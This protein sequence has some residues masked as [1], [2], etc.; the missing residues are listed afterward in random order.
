MAGTKISDYATGNDHWT[1]LLST[2]E[3][4]RKGKMALSLTNY[5][6]SSLPA[7][8][9]GSYLE[10]NGAL[11]GFTSEEA[12]GG[13]ATTDNINYVMVDPTPVTAAWT[14]VTPTWAPNK[15]AWMDAGEAKRYI[16]GCCFITP[17][18][19]HKFLYNKGRDNHFSVV[20]DIGDWNMDTGPAN[21]VA[22]GLVVEKIQAT[23]VM[24]RDDTDIRHYTLLPDY[25]GVTGADGYVNRV[26]T[27]YVEMG[28]RDTGVFDSD[29]FDSTSYNRGWITIDFEA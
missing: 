7:I 9:A 21:N 12:I 25:G 15:N 28:R 26:G 6:N 1:E 5:D 4:Q 8:E 22:H 3:K 10:I 16:G 18:Y 2:I 27:L 20:I 29:V 17:N 24:I 23:S 13:S 11:Y 19:N 14:L